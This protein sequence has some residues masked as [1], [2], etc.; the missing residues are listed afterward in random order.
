MFSKD[1][2]MVLSDDKIL[3]EQFATPENDSEFAYPDTN[4]NFTDSWY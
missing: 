3:V 1:N 4:V 2:D